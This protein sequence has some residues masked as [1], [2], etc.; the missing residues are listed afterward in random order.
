MPITDIEKQIAVEA[1]FNSSWK[2]YMGALELGLLHNP[3]KL[4]ESRII[5]PALAFICKGI[6]DAGV[7]TAARSQQVVTVNTAYL[8]D[9]GI[10]T[11]ENQVTVAHELA[12]HLTYVLMPQFKQWHGPEFKHIMQSIGYS[13][14]TYHCM[15][16]SSAK[17]V[18]AQTRNNTVLFEL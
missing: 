2:Q 3:L 15:S 5:K 6:G 18:A 12:H 9:S 14:D 7:Y 13:G 4:P 11:P 17:R 10:L 1:Y 16:V 8:P